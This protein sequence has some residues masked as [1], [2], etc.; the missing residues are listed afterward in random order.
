MKEKVKLQKGIFTI[1]IDVELAWGTFDRGGLNKYR[2]S[3][4]VARE[5]VKELLQIFERYQ[6]PVTW[7]FVGHLFLDSCDP[8]KGVNHPEMPRPQYPW[9]KKDWYAE[10]P[11]TD[12][13]SDPS[14]YGKDIL[15]LILASKVRHEIAGHTFSHVDLGHPACLPQVA[16]AEIRRCRELAQRQGLNLKSFV[17][18]KNQVE[19]LD[20]L[21]KYDFI[22]YRGRDKCWSDRF[23]NSLVNKIAQ[24]GEEIFC[25][26]ANCQSPQ[27][28][29]P[30]LWNIPGS[31]IYRSWYGFMSL[32]PLSWRVGKAKRGLEQ[33]IKEKKVFQLWFHLWH[34]G[35]GAERLRK[36]LEKIIKYALCQANKRNLEIMTLQ[37]IARCC[38]EQRNK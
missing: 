8:Q 32:L 15:D 1:S 36:G 19:H 23:K 34:F 3:F 24:F 29:L 4:E 9:L 21:K 22:C 20:L 28:T 2:R 11:G 38:A 30:G 31:M 17:F 6:I 16:E 5:E 27:E 33:A 35:P 37:D 26:P 10:D 18:P 12:V 25:F 14:W 13:H 7:A